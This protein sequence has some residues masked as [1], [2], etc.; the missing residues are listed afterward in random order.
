MSSKYRAILVDD[1]PCV[2][3]STKMALLRFGYCPVDDFTDGSDA[4]NS[5][6]N[7]PE[8]VKL[9][10]TD[11]RMPMARMDGE[12]LLI[13]LKKEGYTGKVV[14]I[15]GMDQEMTRR[16]VTELGVGTEL[17]WEVLSKPYDLFGN[18]KNAVTMDN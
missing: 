11:M 14:V 8:T 13:G 10:I 5:Y 12:Q 16:K 9:I 1:E 15:S 7:E 2:R 6:R 3:E 17:E 4:L 18:F